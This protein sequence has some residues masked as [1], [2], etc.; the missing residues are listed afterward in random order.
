[1]KDW[2][3]ENPWCFTL[4]LIAVLY[5]VAGVLLPILITLI[6]GIVGLGVI[7]NLTQLN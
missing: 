7:E 2:I 1:M 3:K 5:I 6:A 4:I